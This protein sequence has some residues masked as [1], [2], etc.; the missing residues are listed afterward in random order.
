M[1]QGCICRFVVNDVVE[2][3]ALDLPTLFAA[4]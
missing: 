2:F 3:Q 4:E 1:A